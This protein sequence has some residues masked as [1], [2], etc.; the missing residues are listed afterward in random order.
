MKK[1]TRHL[2]KLTRYFVLLCLL[3]STAGWSI[4]AKATDGDFLPKGTQ[5]CAD[6]YP[7]HWTWNDWGK[8]SVNSQMV[9]D[10]TFSGCE[11]TPLLA[12][13]YGGSVEITTIDPSA[14][15]N[16]IIWRDVSGNEEFHLAHL[17]DFGDLTE[18]GTVG[19]RF[20]NLPAGFKIGTLGNTGSASTGAHLHISSR[21]NGKNTFVELSGVKLKPLVNNVAGTCLNK[22]T[23]RSKGPMSKY[24]FFQVYKKGPFDT[25]DVA[26]YPPDKSCEKADMWM[27]DGEPDINNV[28]NCPEMTSCY[29]SCRDIYERLKNIYLWSSE[30]F[31]EDKWKRIFFG[32]GPLKEEH[33][34]FCQ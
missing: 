14:W 13:E 6:S 7:S 10:I 15:G 32:D 29:C 9:N 19:A 5:Y 4:P 24:D 1:V 11:G 17:N 23:Y 33:I 8:D 2:E 31:F 26:W 18:K 3:V 28:C 30:L 34:K 16:S 20:N 25:V 12:P 21:V 22:K 27:L